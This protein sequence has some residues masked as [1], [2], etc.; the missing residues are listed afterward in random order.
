MLLLLAALHIK[1]S[2]VLQVY[3]FIFKYY[4]FYFMPYLLNGIWLSVISCLVSRSAC[5]TCH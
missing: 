4:F 1:E 2:D 3:C 5:I